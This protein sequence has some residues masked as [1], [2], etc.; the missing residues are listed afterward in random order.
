MKYLVI[1]NEG[2]C[3]VRAFTLLG[4]SGARGDAKKIGQFGSGAK[5]AMLIAMRAN[6]DIRITSGNS[7]VTPMVDEI[8]VNNRMYQQ[9]HFEYYDTQHNTRNRAE[10]SMTLDFGELD[11]AAEIP[12]M[13]R[14]FVSNA[15]DSTDQSWSRIKVYTATSIE[16]A[17]NKT[18]VYIEFRS[19]VKDVYS[20]IDDI[21]LHSRGLQDSKVMRIEGAARSAKIYRKGVFVRQADSKERALFDYNCGEELKIDESRKYEGMEVNS[22]CAQTMFN[23]QRDT[24]DIISDICEVLKAGILD[25]EH[26]FEHDFGYGP[27]NSYQAAIAVKKIWG[28]NICVTNSSLLFHQ[29]L[30]KGVQCILF[31]TFMEDWFRNVNCHCKDV[32]SALDGQVAYF[33]QVKEIS[34]PLVDRIT[35]LMIEMGFFQIT[36]PRP[37]IFT[38]Q[39]I[40]EGGATTKGY[41]NG[42]DIYLC[43][44][45]A[46]NIS[47]ILEELVHHYT[48]S[49]DC[50]R[51]IQQIAFDIAGRLI[52]EKLA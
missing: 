45:D 13:I 4:V 21:F 1:E 44:D 23:A 34:S 10:S 25:H 24:D 29:A 7:I 17:E 11:W 20:R 16:A 49:K 39:S 12:M 6:L 27:I 47:T 30:A 50:T 14:E 31:P 33:Q 15:L 3:D 40:M 51:D 52:Q 38:F 48:G 37:R 46:N 28:E 2:E 8:F 42:K 19:D 18:R 5:H 26:V 32:L 41:S 22:V 43:H 35:N 36:K 9:V